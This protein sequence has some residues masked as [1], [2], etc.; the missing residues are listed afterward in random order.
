MTIHYMKSHSFF[1]TGGAVTLLVG[2]HLKIL[3]EA[4]PFPKA[5]K[6]LLGIME[7]ERLTEYTRVLLLAQVF[8]ILYV[9]VIIFS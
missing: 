4:N 9:L 6:E 8:I 5:D 1:N 3:T 7:R 2:K